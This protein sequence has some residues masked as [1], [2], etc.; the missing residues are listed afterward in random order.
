M[1]VENV[2]VKDGQPDRFALHE[3][4]PRVTQKRLL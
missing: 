2:R 3:C 4:V 1:D